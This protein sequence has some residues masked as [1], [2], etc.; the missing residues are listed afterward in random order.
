MMYFPV[1]E[2]FL[3][4][5][6]DAR[7]GIDLLNG[8]RLG[9]L[10]GP[11]P[12]PVPRIVRLFYQNLHRDY[13]YDPRGNRFQVLCSHVDG[14]DIDIDRHLLAEVL[15]IFGTRDDEASDHREPIPEDVSLQ[16]M[17]QDISE[18][19]TPL[20][21]RFAR[22]GDLVQGLWF[23]DNVLKAN[24]FALSHKDER[25]NE[26]LRTLYA[27]RHN[28][29]LSIADVIIT[30]MGRF[31][32]RP[33]KRLPFSNIIA[34][35]IARA[36]THYPRPFEVSSTDPPDTRPSIY[37]SG[38]W[39][40]S[41]GAL[42]G[43]LPHP[44]R[45][46]VV[47]QSDEPQST[48]SPH[49]PSHQPSPSHAGPSTSSQHSESPWSF[50]QGDYES[51]LAGQQELRDGLHEVRDIQM[52]HGEYFRRIMAALNINDPLPWNPPPQ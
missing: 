43:R 3:A 47:P 30:Q 32:D 9:G 18:G 5:C 39:T 22:H 16:L 14:Y 44:A 7:V 19:R 8:R 27:L 36:T 2:A 11:F 49:R 20:G 42:R 4:E 17:A 41:V 21:E 24:V 12:P 6:P 31:L 48:H 51:I 52:T 23:A 33:E 28:H 50:S 13:R 29:Q 1:M 35:Y 25:R 38:S 40:K 46:P 15:R 10:F 45:Q 34:P 26:A 37:I